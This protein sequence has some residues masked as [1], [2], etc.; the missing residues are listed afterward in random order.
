VSV[1][2]GAAP[3]ADVT[4]TLAPATLAALGVTATPASLTFTAANFQAP[5]SFVV[6]AIPNGNN[7]PSPA[8]G[9]LQV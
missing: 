6:T 4:V 9:D 5:Q 1:R 3:T 7:L 2:L 8:R